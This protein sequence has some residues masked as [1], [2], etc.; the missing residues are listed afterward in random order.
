MRNMS[1]HWSLQCHQ[2]ELSY[3]RLHLT[4]GYKHQYSDCMVCDYV[5]KLIMV[6]QIYEGYYLIK[7]GIWNTFTLL[8]SGGPVIIST[9]TLLT[10]LNPT[11]PRSLVMM[12]LALQK[13]GLMLSCP[14]IMFFTRSSQGDQHMSAT[15][16]QWQQ[17]ATKHQFQGVQTM[18][19]HQYQ[20]QFRGGVISELIKNSIAKKGRE[21]NGR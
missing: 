19:Q 3:Y 16:K 12:E 9:E 10:H 15:R 14:D 21:N 13:H 17:L 2:M 18:S 20:H 4:P 11:L 8:F 5:G 1:G 6:K 7:S